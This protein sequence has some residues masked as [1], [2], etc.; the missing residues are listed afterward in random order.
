MMYFVSSFLS[1]RT[2]FTLN[3]AC[4]MSSSSK[5]QTATIT[6]ATAGRTIGQPIDPA[7]TKPKTNPGYSE[8]TKEKRPSSSSSRSAS[9]LQR[10]RFINAEKTPSMILLD[11]ASKSQ[12]RLTKVCG[13]CIRK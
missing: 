5:S 7:P 9:A 11:M 6:T 4:D 8:K 10:D 2:A 13:I 1:C 12:Y 3:T